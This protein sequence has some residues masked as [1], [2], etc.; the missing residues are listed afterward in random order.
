MIFP[1]CYTTGNILAFPYNCSQ[2]KGLTYAKL[3]WDIPRQPIVDWNGDIPI[4]S[5][6]WSDDKTVYVFPE[7]SISATPPSGPGLIDRAAAGI[8]RIL[9][10]GDR[11]TGT[12]RVGGYAVIALVGAALLFWYVP[13]KKR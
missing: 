10:S 4:T 8:N 3:S 5:G 12:A 9:D 1:R 7:G 13:R 6:Q 2:G 11:A